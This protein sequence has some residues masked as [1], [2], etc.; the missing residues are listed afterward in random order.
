MVAMIGDIFLA[1]TIEMQ[2]D[3]YELMKWMETNLSK[4]QLCKDSQEE[5]NTGLKNTS[6]LS[7]ESSQIEGAVGKMARAMRKKRKQINQE[8]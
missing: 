3:G 4:D 2:K 6:L 5:R 1:Q 7:I 8:L